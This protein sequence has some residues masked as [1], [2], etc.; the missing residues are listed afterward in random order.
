[1]NDNHDFADLHRLGQMP[2]DILT[3]TEPVGTNV[4][5]HGDRDSIELIP[6]RFHESIARTI[7]ALARRDGSLFQ[8]D[9][10]LVILA[11]QGNQPPTVRQLALPALPERLT[12]VAQFLKRRAPTSSAPSE[13]VLCEPP[14]NLVAGVH[15]RGD[16]PGIRK[17]N[18]IATTPIL[19]EDGTMCD[20]S[21][22]DA[23]TGFYAHIHPGFPAIP[24]SPS[25]EDA[26]EALE[27]LAQPF[28]DFPFQTEA[29]LSA[30]LAAILTGIG[31]SAIRGPCPGFL[32]EANT[33]GTGKSLLAQ[34]IG[35]IVSGQVVASSGLSS[36]EEERRKAILADLCAS[37]QVI[38]YDDVAGTI[39][40]AALNR[41]LTAS[42]VADRQLGTSQ[43]RA[44]PVNAVVLFTA[45]N[46]RV[47]GDTARRLLP[48]R[49]I[50]DSDRPEDRG[51]FQIPDLAGFVT[52]R[53][54]ALVAAALTV[55]RAWFAAGE[56]DQGLPTWGSFEAW[57][58]VVRNALV[59]A[60]REDPYVAGADLRRA[61][62]DDGAPLS[63]LLV[64]LSA[65][66]DSMGG[67][68][69]SKEVAA[70]AVLGNSRVAE[71]LRGL[72][73]E[74]SA[75]WTGKEVGY[76]LRQHR[77]KVVAGKKLVQDAGRDRDGQRWRVEEATRSR[78]VM[79]PRNGPG[80]AKQT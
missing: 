6:D 11:A 19:R 61:E 44:Y 71:A 5:N 49:Q 24:S 60:G 77:D 8:R 28:A 69:T 63:D 41:L 51:A 25:R 64:A 1:M 40:G 29:H 26:A 30:A 3:D 52:E 67:A 73:G 45:N 13:W 57:S 78:H 53:R 42:V 9:D 20:A 10:G 2:K 23:A 36:D 50:A 21:G 59:W 48:V 70:A 46:P 76:L 56:P 17:L 80:K 54:S 47:V 62:A 34:C 32:L 31:R 15:S 74:Q 12:R 72:T 27:A 37:P 4:P 16:W 33:R 58:R 79:R 65:L 75:A 55:L 35:R 7:S 18:G 22:Y 38:I 39:G 68:V 66:C 14:R 43:R